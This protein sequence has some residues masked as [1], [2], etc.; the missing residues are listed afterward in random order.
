[1]PRTLPKRAGKR[2]VPLRPWYRVRKWATHG[3]RRP[4]PSA[5]WRLPRS[6]QLELLDVVRLRYHLMQLAGSRVQNGK[7]TPSEGGTVPVHPVWQVFQYAGSF[8]RF[9]CIGALI[10]GEVE[11][12]PGNFVGSNDR[13]ETDPQARRSWGPEQA[14]VW[15]GTI[16]LAK[17]GGRDTGGRPRSSVRVRSR[18]PDLVLGLSTV[19][20]RV[21]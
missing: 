15:A 6:S 17:H 20:G 2:F 9:I 12:L 21:A 8:G 19:V 7:R 5:P 13:S 18:R 3:A 10:L 1:M 14:E 11:H 4:R 16:V